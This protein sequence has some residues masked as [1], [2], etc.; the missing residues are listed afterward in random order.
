MHSVL[1]FILNT[2][3]YFAPVYVKE[4][5]KDWSFHEIVLFPDNVV[6]REVAF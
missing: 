4:K 5:P 6:K 2:T 3:K 1:Y